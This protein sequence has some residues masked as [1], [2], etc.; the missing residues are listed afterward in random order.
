MTNRYWWDDVL[1]EPQIHEFQK[2]LSLMERLI[3]MYSNPGDIVFDPFFG[4]GSTLKAAAHLGRVPMGCEI[5]RH[6][7]D[8]FCSTITV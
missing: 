3:R 1:Q 2:P 4:S 7:Y 8:M 5:D 6:Y